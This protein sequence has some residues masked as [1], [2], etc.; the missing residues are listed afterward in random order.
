MSAILANCVVLSLEGP[1]PSGQVCPSRQNLV[2]ELCCF[3]QIRSVDKHTQQPL[4]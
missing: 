4:V 1:V 2:Y 3:N